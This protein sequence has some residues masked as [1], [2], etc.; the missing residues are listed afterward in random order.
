[1]NLYMRLILVFIRTFSGERLHHSAVTESRF[2]VFLHDLDAFGHMNNGRYLQIMDVARTEWML[3][4]GVADAIRKERWA[5]MLGGGVVRYRHSLRLFQRYTVRTRLLGWD[6]R[7]F[8]LEHSFMDHRDRC[9]AV[10][11]KRAGLR[12]ENRWVGT[13]EVVGSVHPGATSPAIPAHVLDWVA[14]EEAMYRS[15]AHL[16]PHDGVATLRRAG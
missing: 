12:A 3:R 15:G 14:L 16:S 2:R 8:Y 5:P 11:V 4:T 7:W 6:E 1:M 10:G 9:V 13:E